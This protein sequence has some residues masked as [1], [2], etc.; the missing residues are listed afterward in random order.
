MSSSTAPASA[1]K[2]SATMVGTTNAANSAKQ[3]AAAKM[4]RRSRNGKP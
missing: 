1:G 4:H 2:Q 3:A